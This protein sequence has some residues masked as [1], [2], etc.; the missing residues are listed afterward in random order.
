MISLQGDRSSS[1][2]HGGPTPPFLS[3]TSPLGL[4]PIHSEQSIHRLPQQSWSQE[5]H[6]DTYTCPAH[7]GPTWVSLTWT[8][9]GDIYF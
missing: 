8:E 9:L 1:S 5:V 2:E 6:E 7:K 3:G 4:L